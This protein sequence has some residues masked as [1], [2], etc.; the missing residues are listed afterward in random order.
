M[1]AHSAVQIDTERMRE[2]LS[3]L[4][5]FTFQV[6]RVLTTFTTS[7]CDIKINMQELVNELGSNGA[8]SGELA[9]DSSNVVTLV[10]DLYNVSE[11]FN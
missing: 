1:H 3:E 8:F 7:L 11:K 10:Q 4:T 9:A 6:P 5:I 2:P